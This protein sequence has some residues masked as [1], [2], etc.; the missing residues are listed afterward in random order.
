MK[1]ISFVYVVHEKGRQFRAKIGKANVPADRLAGI[2]ASIKREEGNA[3][4]VRIFVT[5]PTLVPFLVER[6]LHAFADL[7]YRKDLTARGSGK[8]EY[9]WYLN[10]MCFLLAYICMYA[11]PVFDNYRIY[12]AA[13]LLL[14]PRPLDFALF[15]VLCFIGEWAAVGTILYSLVLFIKS[16]L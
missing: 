14:W 9:Y 1:I 12:A 10:I 13:A 15:C 16:I 6:G 8:T 3:P 5:V 7:W 11:F 4:D 2:A